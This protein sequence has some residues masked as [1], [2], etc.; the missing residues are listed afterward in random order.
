M[1]MLFL[2]LIPAVAAQRASV[3]SPICRTSI[4]SIGESIPVPFTDTCGN[5]VNCP[6]AEYNLNRYNGPESCTCEKI[7]SPLQGI[8]PGQLGF[9]FGDDEADAPEVEDVPDPLDFS[10]FSGPSS[11]PC[12]IT[13]SE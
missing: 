3:F 4:I 10:G 5:I 9:N 13:Y 7:S 2:L 8:K 12:D 6:G 1:F 11:V